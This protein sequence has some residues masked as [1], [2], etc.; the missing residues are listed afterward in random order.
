MR[1]QLSN[2]NSI[3]FICRPSSGTRPVAPDLVWRGRLEQRGRES[4][5]A[6]LSVFKGFFWFLCNYPKFGAPQ[7]PS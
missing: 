4:P 7:W 2:P 5:S 6:Y 1:L 3:G